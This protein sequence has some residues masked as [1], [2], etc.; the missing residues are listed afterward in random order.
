[1]INIDGLQIE[2]EKIAEIIKNLYISSQAEK[3]SLSELKLESERDES[4]SALAS[5]FDCY[6]DAS[7]KDLIEEAKKEAEEIISQARLESEKILE[8]SR[9]AAKKESEDIKSEALFQK[10]RLKE[11]ELFF[12]KKMDILKAGFAQL[13][14]DKKAFEK[15][16]REELERKARENSYSGPGDSATMLFAG[17]NSLLALKKRYKDLIKIFHPDNL[18]GDTEVLQLINREYEKLNDEF[19]WVRKAY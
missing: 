2:E 5:D 4:A 19:G 16:K 6:M 11:Q 15:I 7:P 13:E 10:G 8:E 12:D 17:V 9:I 14:A 18:C 1:M 3:S